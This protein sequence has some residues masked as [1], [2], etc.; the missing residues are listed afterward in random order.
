M[1]LIAKEYNLPLVVHVIGD[2][3]IAHTIEVMAAI[4][5]AGNPL[6]SGLIHHQITDLD[7]LKNSGA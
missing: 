7:L 5:D 1:G 2:G 3:A 4:N 6:R